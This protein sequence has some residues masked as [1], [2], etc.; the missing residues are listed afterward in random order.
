ML[1]NIIHF[2][3]YHNFFTL[4]IVVVFVGGGTAFAAS[5]E[6]REIAENTLI[7]KIEVIVS[8]D[9]TALLNTN[10]DNF[11]PALVIMAISEDADAYYVS[12]TFN[13]FAVSSGAWGSAMKE[14]ELTV[15]KDNLGS[16]DL[17]VYVEEE[18]K[19]VAQ[20]EISYLKEVKTAEQKKGDTKKTIAVAY[21]GLLGL[22]IDTKEKEVEYKTVNVPTPTPTPETTPTVEPTSNQ[23]SQSSDATGQ[24]TSTDLVTPLPSTIS[25]TTPSDFDTQDVQVVTSTTTATS[26]ATT[27]LITI[28]IANATTTQS[29]ATTTLPM[30]E[31]ATSTATS[32]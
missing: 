13:T 18:L 15:F 1:K 25:T 27:T 32:T 14:G 30:V 3:K 2:V 10:F 12:Y 6:L 22:V 11:D 29:V 26:T 21:T 4:A 9:N 17:R 24:A 28:S 5:P 20:A 16:E 7:G 31:T 23:S 8:I 19:E